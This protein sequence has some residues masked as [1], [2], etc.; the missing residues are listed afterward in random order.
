MTVA[1]YGLAGWCRSWYFSATRRASRSIAIASWQSPRE[2]VN[3]MAANRL[4]AL[5][6]PSVQVPA[7]TMDGRKQWTVLTFPTN[8]LIASQTW[9]PAMT[10]PAGFTNSGL[11]VGF[12]FV[13][14]PY[15]EPTVFRLG[16]AFEQ[17]THHRCRPSPRP[18]WPS[19]PRRRSHA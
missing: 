12:E 15:D 4:G 7:P 16:Y 11:P 14:K 2:A 5:V 17:A 13:A 3:V 8:T 19:P 6:Y 1:P 9:M 10:V 18:S